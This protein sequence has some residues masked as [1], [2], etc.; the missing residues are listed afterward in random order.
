MPVVE[1]S[2]ASLLLRDLSRSAGE[3][4]GTAQVRALLVDC[5]ALWGVSGR[6]TTDSC[7]VTITTDEGIFSLQPAPT[8]L[9]PVRWFL[10]TPEREIANRPPRALPSIV[11]SL[12]ALRNALGG[13]AG[14]R[15]R[16]GSF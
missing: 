4:Y 9:H 11:A 10:R 2:P 1:P 7:G 12:S 15:L 3:V 14:V 16:V 6:V 8:D 5:L 13:E